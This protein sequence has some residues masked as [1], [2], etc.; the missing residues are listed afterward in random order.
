MNHS[1]DLADFAS[2]ASDSGST[3]VDTAATGV[4]DAAESGADRTALPYT[5]QSNPALE[6]GRTD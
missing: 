2:R 1:G 6:R 3:V 5:V 4:F